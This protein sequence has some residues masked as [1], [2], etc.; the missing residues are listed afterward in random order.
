MRTAASLLAALVIVGTGLFFL[1]TRMPAPQAPVTQKPAVASPAPAEEV[2]PAA[3]A[4]G[5]PVTPVETTATARTPAA[6]AADLTGAAQIHVSAAAAPGGDGSAARPFAT[7]EQARDAARQIT[8]RP[9]QVNVGPG[10]YIVRNG[11]CLGAVD[12]G[13][14]DRRMVYRAVP[15]G[16]ARVSSGVLVP[17]SALLPV[18][19]E[20][21]RSRL[22][23]EVRDDVR[24]IDLDAAGLQAARFKDNFKG[25]EL[26][27]VLSG[28]ERL[29]ISRWPDGGKYAQMDTVLENGIE[30]PA[31]GIFVYREDEPS[32]WTAAVADGLWLRGFWRVPWVIEAVRIGAIDPQAKTITLAVPVTRGIGSKYHRA[33]GD[34]KGSG[35]GEEPWEA[36]NLIE[37]ISV[38][39]EWAVRFTDGTFFILP[40]EGDN[41]LLISDHT[42]PVIHLEEASHLSLEGFAVDGGLG[43]GIRV[44]GGENVLVAGC[45]VSNVSRDGIALSGGKNHTVLSCDTA[46]T[47]Y[48]GI[49]YLGGDRWTLEPSGH[50]VINNLVRRAGLFF[51]APGI[52]GGLDTKNQPVG[53][54]IA[55]N[56][57]HDCMNS[58]IVYAGNDNLF[59]YNEI[60][61]VGLGSSDLGCFYTNSGWTSRGNVIKHN[62]VHHS[63][64]ANAFYVDDGD[65]GDTFFGNIAYKTESGG[66]IGGGHDQT[67]LNNIIVESPRAMHIDARGIPRKY[68][69]DDKRLRRD[70][71]SVPY[72]RPPWSERYPELLGILETATERPARIVIKDNLFVACDTPLRRSGEDDEF[73]GLTFENNVVSDDL[74]MFVDPDNLDFTLKPDAP[75]FTEIPGFEQIPVAKIGL[76]ADAYRP[77]VPPR[78]MEQLRTE[79][80]DRGFDSQTDVN[81]S[82]RPAP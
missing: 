11:F 7:L 50:R 55:H 24:W 36:F 12:S 40:P 61:R 72:D 62:L 43:D 75:V 42:G 45:R 8:D 31:T 49:A 10:H 52:N 44:D 17:R 63:M 29:P 65:C 14:P 33:P 27:E 39:G 68:T 2:L 73:E 16:G 3:P 53:A 54:L 20:T 82:N 58:G 74:G 64:N 79:A 34:G 57:I 25:I 46:E 19:D 9:V 13:S 78:N 5:Q 30:P 28:E 26:L 15:A 1:L 47:G 71:D 48:S 21:L 66:F 37:E 77:V 76:Y 4:Q 56:R 32:R 41:D 6:T 51:P 18:T 60:Y 81:A 80:T 59:E 35:S 38:P 22:R 70:L 67:F 23:E 69:V